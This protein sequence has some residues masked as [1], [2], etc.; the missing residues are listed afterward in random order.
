MGFGRLV[1]VV[2]DRL[3]SEIAATDLD[4]ESRKRAQNRRRFIPG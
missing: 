4:L 2:I 1:M 3:D